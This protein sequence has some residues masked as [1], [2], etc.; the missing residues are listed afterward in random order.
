MRRK[1]NKIKKRFEQIVILIICMLIMVTAAAQRDGKVWGHSL[2]A[3]D[4][5][6]MTGKTATADTIRTLDDG[7]MVVNTTALAKDI[8][9]FLAIF[10]E[11]S[12][13]I[14][15]IR[16]SSATINGSLA[17]AGIGLPAA[18]VI[19]KLTAG[20]AIP[21]MIPHFAPSRQPPKITGR[22]I[23]SHLTPPSL[24]ATRCTS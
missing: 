6:A 13:A 21:A 22:Y 10:S 4:T 14:S 15:A 9:G 17:A 8:S 3:D 12:P 1:D 19:R 11:K 24:P 16:V 20:D 5:T 2:S 23:G 7:T 18:E